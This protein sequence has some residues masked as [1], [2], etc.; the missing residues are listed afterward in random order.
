MLV[1][2]R[3]YYLHKEP[4]LELAGTLLPVPNELEQEL[5]WAQSRPL[6][7]AYG[8]S[9]L[10][11][12]E[13][14]NAFLKA[15]N[16]GEESFRLSY[17]LTHPNQAWQ[18]NQNPESGFG[19][20]STDHC[21]PTV[22]AN[23]HMLFTEKIVPARWIMGSEALATQGFPIIPFL[24]NIH[25]EQFPKLCSFNKPRPDRT[26]R[27]LLTQAGNSMNVYVMTLMML[28]GLV[29]WQRKPLPGLFQDIR[30]SRILTRVDK[31]ARNFEDP[32]PPQKRLR[33]KT[34]L[35]P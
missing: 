4:N 3:Y 31:R 8:L 19:A 17:A 20:A 33:A 2:C 29:E 7:R 32:M 24:W 15:L 16:F 6:S 28:H 30:S 12:K 26:S 35:E 25:P 5:K 18:L 13:D 23:A 22:V 10:N 21:F 34:H 27:H 1:C 14:D 9:E 11:F